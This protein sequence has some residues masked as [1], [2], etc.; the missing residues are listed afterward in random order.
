MSDLHER[1]LNYFKSLNERDSQ[2]FN[3]QSTGGPGVQAHKINSL[4]ASKKVSLP[5]AKV[6]PQIKK[7]TLHDYFPIKATPVIQEKPKPKKANL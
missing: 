6:A 5:K 7:Y 3:T 4:N 2:M 1:I